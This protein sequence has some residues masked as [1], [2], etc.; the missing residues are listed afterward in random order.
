M[1]SRARRRT[2]PA[3]A[4]ALLFAVLLVVP[5]PGARG[6]EDGGGGAV[7]TVNT[8]CPQISGP[9]SIVGLRHGRGRWIHVV[10]LSTTWQR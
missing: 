7:S 3:V 1:L 9:S 8:Y 10:A 5:G 2:W 4:A 6:A